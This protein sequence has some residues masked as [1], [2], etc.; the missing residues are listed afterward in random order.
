MAWCPKC[1]NEYRE[2]ITVCAECGCE[3]VEEEQ[4]VKRV[5]IV[6]GDEKHMM[7]LAKYLEYNEFKNIAVVYDKNQKLY[8]LLVDEADKEKATK[9]CKVFIEQKTKEEMMQRQMQMQQMQQ[10]MMQ[11]QMMQ[12]MQAA[13]ADEAKQ[14]SD[15]EASKQETVQNTEQGEQAGDNTANAEDNSGRVSVP[16]GA[17]LDSA[18]KAEDNRSSAWTLLLVGGLGMLFLILGITGVLPFKVG[19]PYMFYGVMS[20]IFILF[21]VMGFVSMKNAKFFAKNAE[22]ETNLKNTLLDWCKE[23]LKAEEIDAKVNTVGIGYEELCLRRYEFIKYRINHQFMN[24]DQNFL[25]RLID[26]DV[27]EMVYP[28]EEQ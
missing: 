11:Q 18:K 23:N 6:Y 28:A 26:D 16:A 14:E 1:K 13:A 4:M 25:D 10:Q 3:L 22:S 2:G 7:V 17:Y 27:Y 21:I 15:E 24:L 5:P 9:L 19:N 8:F 20:A 12:Q